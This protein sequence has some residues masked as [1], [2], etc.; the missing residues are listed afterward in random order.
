MQY[1]METLNYFMSGLWA[2]TICFLLCI[3]QF[4]AGHCDDC[5]PEDQINNLTSGMNEIGLVY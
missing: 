5:K 1:Q 3:L 2:N 4:A